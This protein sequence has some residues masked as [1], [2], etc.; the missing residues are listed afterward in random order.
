[1]YRLLRDRVPG[2]ARHM[3]PH[4]SRHDANEAFSEV[5]DEMG[6][7]EAEERQ[8]RNYTYGWEKQSTQGD[9]YV[10]RHVARAAAQAFLRL[11]RKAS[12]AGR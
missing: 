9:R 1:M 3:S 6:L 11:Q 2:V 7:D 8:L 10:R 4:V 12:D 5:A